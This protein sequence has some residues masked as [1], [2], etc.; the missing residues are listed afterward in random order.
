MR[1]AEN[2][3]QL[4]IQVIAVGDHDDGGIFHRSFLH[5][6]RSKTSHG[7]ALAATLCMPDNTTL[8]ANI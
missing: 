1:H 2:T 6:S 8:A 3:K 5:Y 7:D 4:A